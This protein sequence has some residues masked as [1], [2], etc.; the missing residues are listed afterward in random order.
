MT[1]N[2]ASP[3]PITGWVEKLARLIRRKPVTQEE[4]LEVLRQAQQRNLLDQDSLDMIERVFQVSELRARDIMVARSKM[5]VVDRNAAPEEFLPLVIES[6]HSRFPTIDDDRDKVVGIMLAKDLLRY[7][8]GDTDHFNM[9][10]LLRPAV[11]VPES[12]RLNVLLGEFRAN[13][14][15]MAIVVDEYGGVAGLVTI[16]DVIEQ[17]VGDIE[18]EHD[19][20]EEASMV[21]ER[22]DHE[23]IIKA[24][25]PL[26]DFN[27]R[28]N[29]DFDPE[30]ID[31]V[32]GLIINNL[33]H[34]PMRG[35]VAE[36][37]ELRFEVLNADSRRVHLVKMTRQN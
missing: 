4:L 9:R 31:T 34:V 15:H 5:V 16:E 18:D 14:N 10:D 13:R 2:Q 3:Q 37:G 11:F 19:I 35:E 20:D 36:I 17:I 8:E 12:K 27:E 7:F 23:F 30:E 6:A 32:G 24:L 33:G 25:L 21:M 1:R 28:F 22:G 29:T 26:Q